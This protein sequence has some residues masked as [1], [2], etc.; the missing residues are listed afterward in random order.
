VGKLALVVM[1]AGVGSRY[2]GPK[3]LEPIGPN[4]ETLSDY[5][6]YN[7]LQIGCDKVAFILSQEVED[8]FR[9]RVG[10]R[11]ERHCDVAYVIQRI[12]D[13]PVGFAV[14]PER[15]KPWGTAHAIL[16]C[17]NAVSTPFVVVNGD[18]FY[19][20]GAFASLAPWLAETSAG[21][22]I[23]DGCLVGYRAENTLSEHGPVTRGVCQVDSSGYLVRIDER[24]RVQRFGTTIRYSEDG[25]HWAEVAPESSVSMNMW[26]FPPGVLSE[27]AARFPRFL[28]SHTTEIEKAEFILPSVVHDLV[29]EGRLR[30]RVLPTAERWFGLTHPEDKEGAKAAIAE[31][32]RRGEYPQTLWG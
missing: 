19:G 8:A 17:K 10:R 11:I 15:R 32:I 20:R 25:E 22:G 7:A 2:G 16:S 9:S 5:S 29:K 27:L 1:A 30:V 6:V 18:D 23:L 12:E 3:Q 21:T 31:L 24:R 14:P 4:G 13:V 26:G 28:Q